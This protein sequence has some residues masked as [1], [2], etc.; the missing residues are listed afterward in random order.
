MITKILL[1][2]ASIIYKCNFKVYRYLYFH[3]K[4]IIDKREISILKKL[5]KPD[6]CIIDIGANIG[7]YS[8]LFSKMIVNGKIHSFEPDKENYLHLEKLTNHLAIIKINQLAVADEKKTVKLYKS[9]FLNVDHRIYEFPE[10]KNPTEMQTI[11]VDE[12][13]KEKF[14]VDFIK[15]DIQGAEYLALKGM[16]KTVKANPNCLI[17]MEFWPYG[18]KQFGKKLSE[19]IDLIDKMNLRIYVIQ[20]SKIIAKESIDIEYYKQ[21]HPF[22]YENWLLCNR[23]NK[24]N[25]N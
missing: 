25:I 5:I 14:R 9:T 1:Q 6:F 20:K 19:V 12:Y 2:L 22:K 10:G 21:F 8:I 24:I 3:Y 23:T 16:L 15:M 11:S 13:V 4:Y 18:I 7:F 17:L